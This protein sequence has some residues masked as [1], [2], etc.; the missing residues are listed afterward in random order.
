M[1]FLDETATITTKTWR[2]LEDQL[3]T[4]LLPWPLPKLPTYKSGH[5][6]NW[7]CRPTFEMNGAT[8][9][10][11]LPHMHQPKG[12]MFRRDG[13]IWMSLTKMEVESQMHHIAAATGHTVIAGLGMGFVLYNI[14]AKPEVTKVTLLEIDPNVV[15]LMDKVTQW[16]KW[17]GFDKVTIALG[18]AIKWQATEPVDFLYADI[19]DRLGA[20]EALEVT[21]KIQAGAKAKLVGYWGQ[22]FDFADWMRES[23]DAAFLANRRRYRAFAQ[24]CGLPLLEQDSLIYPALAMAAV[25]LQIAAKEP[26]GPAKIELQRMSATVLQKVHEARL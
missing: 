12:W 20:H 15:A 6:K 22:E 1:M 23:G 7:A 18:D 16:R 21:Q 5:V 13:K 25:I 10:Y 2:Q 24:T 8:S 11:F 26:P 9:G 4:S 17:P 3:Y 14:I 19:W